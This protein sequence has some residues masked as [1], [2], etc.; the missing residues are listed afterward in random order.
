MP[1]GGSWG[2][3]PSGSTATA[4]PTGGTPILGT[5]TIN[6]MVHPLFPNM[7]EWPVR[8]KARWP[9]IRT[10]TRKAVVRIWHSGWGGIFAIWANFDILWWDISSTVLPPE[11]AELI[12][13]WQRAFD[14]WQAGDY[15]GARDYLGQLDDAIADLELAGLISTP[16][17]DRLRHLSKDIS[18]AI[19]A[20]PAVAPVPDLV[21]PQDGDTLRGLVD[22]IAETVSPNVTGADFQVT[23]DGD[24][25]HKLGWDGDGTDGWSIPCDTVGWSEG[26]ARLRVIMENSLGELGEHD[27]LVWIDNTPPLAA[28]LTPVD[29]QVVCG[30]LPVEVACDP[31]DDVSCVF[32]ITANGTDW[33]EIG[34]DDDATDGLTTLLDTGRMEAAKY[35]L[36]ATVTDEAGNSAQT[37]QWRIAVEPSFVAWK[38]AYGIMDLGPDDDPNLDGVQLGTEYYLDL[39]PNT[40][41]ALADHVTWTP[42]TGTDMRIEF[43]PREMMDGVRCKIQ[44]CGDLDSW[45]DAVV[46][47]VPDPTGL[48]HTLFNANPKRF[49]R[50]NIWED[51]P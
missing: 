7:E 25:W 39:S 43:R 41:N 28:I 29:T 14:H 2:P 46:D 9:G 1:F 48:Y 18:L 3:E 21:Q 13:L 10:Q 5:I 12:Q 37:P 8:V 33:V 50:L 20:L 23:F 31:D 11:L 30:I 47:P 44:T 15:P 35:D 6:S 36:R 24:V 32:E 45:F 51:R 26:T 19:D 40:H 42:S 34:R 17:A 49:V 16:D 38:H 22:L 4:T 27:S